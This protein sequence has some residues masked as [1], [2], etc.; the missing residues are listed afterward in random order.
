MKKTWVE[1][2]KWLQFLAIIFISVTNLFYHFCI[3]QLAN[4]AIEGSN[5]R[6]YFTGVDGDSD[7]KGEIFGVLNLF[8]PLRSGAS[9]TESVLKVCILLH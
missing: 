9:L 3:Q 4:T 1:S 2:L 6:R 8:Q 5:E 7:N